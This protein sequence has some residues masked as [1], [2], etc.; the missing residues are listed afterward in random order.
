MMVVVSLSNCPYSLRGDLTKWL[1]EIDVNVYAGR[2]TSRVKDE[3]WDRITRSIADGRA[4]MIFTTLN[5]QHFDFLVHNGAWEPVDFDGL[6]L[7]LK[8]DLS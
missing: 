5:E 4:I 7:M 1:F 8:S 2:V 3:L 6:K